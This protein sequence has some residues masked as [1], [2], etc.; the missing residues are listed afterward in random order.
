[1]GW[2]THAPIEGHSF[3][4][5]N[6]ETTSYTGFNGLLTDTGFSLTALTNFTVTDNSPSLLSFAEQL[7]AKICTSPDLGGC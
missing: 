4:W 3:I 6:G 5:H 2:F 1:M 7:I